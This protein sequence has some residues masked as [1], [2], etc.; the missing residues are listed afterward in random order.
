MPVYNEEHQEI[1]HFSQLLRGG[2]D[3][4]LQSGRQLVLEMPGAIPFLAEA[5]QDPD[6]GTF[7]AMVLGWLCLEEPGRQ[8]VLQQPGMIGALL[9]LLVEGLDDATHASISHVSTTPRPSSSADRSYVS[10]MVE[11]AEWVG[12]RGQVSVSAIRNLCRGRRGCHAVLE[13][14]GS[15]E[16]LGAILYP[17]ICVC[18]S[19]SRC[20]D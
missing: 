3:S 10:P 14:S 4:T 15:L 20:C 19:G 6:T 2:L 17:C 8:K 11:P 18:G 7:A 5:L 16:I 12:L 1:R 13:S 9:R